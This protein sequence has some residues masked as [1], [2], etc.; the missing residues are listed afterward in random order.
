VIRLGESYAIA[1]PYTSFVAIEKSRVVVGG[2]PMLVAVP[3]ELPDGTNWAG[4]FGESAQLGG[5]EQ[6]GVALHFSRRIE[7]TDVFGVG[8]DAAGLGLDATIAPPGA[9]LKPSADANRSELAD[10]KVQ[11]ASGGKKRE[12][13]AKS[14]ATP[15]DKSKA[16]TGG[17][18]AAAA[19]PP[20]PAIAMPSSAASS[21]A[22]GK[23]SSG[24][25]MPA[26][27][28]A[29]MAPPA[30]GAG[31]G[32]GG[33]MSGSAGNVFGGLGGPGGGRPGAAKD[34]M[35]RRRDRAPAAGEGGRQQRAD[36][37]AALA[38]DV[39][40]SLQVLAS[41]HDEILRF[42]DAE[43]RVSE[44]AATGGD[45]G[46]GAAKPRLALTL[47][48]RDRLV[49]VLDRRLV[50]LALASLL[51]EGDKIPAL[52]SELGVDLEN[53]FVQV[54]MKVA[55]SEKG[56]L[57]AKLLD[58]IRAAG[59]TISADD[60]KRGLVVARIPVSALAKLAAIDGVKRVEPL[61][62]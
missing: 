62:P 31:G 10:E 9:A 11:A 8:G 2:K 3:V 61:A 29:P 20:M 5:Q 6:Q 44:K 48:E 57:D 39:T 15:A 41:E 18:N 14:S 33:G 16:D 23:R 34:D 53:G 22:V 1:T 35:A 12:V 36:P 17:M 24:A 58:A 25:A 54:A 49:R 42:D 28:A 59:A 4:F 32:M 46:S 21:G 38:P 30:G 43:G 52:A 26:P 27:S 55:T 51:G 60:A 19:P 7:T 50:L 45:T 13:F 37:S 47:A 56:E 40:N